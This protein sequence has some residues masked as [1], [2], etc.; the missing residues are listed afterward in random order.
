MGPLK[1]NQYPTAIFHSYV[2]LPEVIVCFS[3]STNDKRRSTGPSCHGHASI[4]LVIAP[5]SKGISGW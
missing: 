4:L 3:S 2:S 5:V 1:K